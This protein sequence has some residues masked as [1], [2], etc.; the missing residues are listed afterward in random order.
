MHIPI[1]SPEEGFN[2]SVDFAFLGAWNFAKEIKNKEQNFNGK[3]IT[4]VPAVRFI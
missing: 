2:A 3:F 4:H 1:V